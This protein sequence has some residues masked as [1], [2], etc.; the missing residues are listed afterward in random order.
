VLPAL[1]NDWKVGSVKGLLA[2]GG[3]EVSIDWNVAEKVEV[4]LVSRIDQVVTLNS[5]YGESVE[6]ELKSGEES[7]HRFEI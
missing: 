4:R 1:S 2:R 7:V 3:V 5:P 6:L